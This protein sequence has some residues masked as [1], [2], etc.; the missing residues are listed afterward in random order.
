MDT[1]VYIGKYLPKLLKFIEKYHLGDK[2]IVWPDLASSHY[3]HK[4]S[5][6]LNEKR[7]PFVSKVANPPNVPKALPIE[8]FWSILADKVYSG[9]WTATNKE[10]LVNRTK[11]KLKNIYLDTVQTMT[12]GIRKQLQKI[13]DKGRF[14]IL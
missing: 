12:E 7:I 6:W 2:Y 11:L 13:E 3:A 9:G 4:T 10:Q 14:S 8:D 5:A 1:D